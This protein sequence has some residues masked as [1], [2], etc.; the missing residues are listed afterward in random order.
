MLEQNYT[1]K[2]KKK[3]LINF[4]L[5]EFIIFKIDFLLLRVSFLIIKKKKEKSN[6][7]YID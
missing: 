6:L 1:Y 2:K 7:I 5:Y 3:K 4:N